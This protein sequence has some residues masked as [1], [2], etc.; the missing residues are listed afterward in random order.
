MKYEITERMKKQAK[1]YA[2]K[3]AK[4]NKWEYEELLQEIYLSFCISEKHYKSDRGL[5]FEG[6][7]IRNIK[8]HLSNY[9]RDKSKNKDNYKTCFKDTIESEIVE[10]KNIIDFSLIFTDSKTINIF[11][12]RFNKDYKYKEIA[13][14][15]DVTAQ[16]IKQIIEENLNNDGL[17][18][19]IGR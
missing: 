18:Q 13:V 10:N 17:L 2:N 16:R 4:G 8:N 9:F 19:K 6:F 15:Y 7:A 3:Y 12:L 11:D 14:I 1:F 5:K